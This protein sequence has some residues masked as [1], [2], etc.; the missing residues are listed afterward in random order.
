MKTSIS[1]PEKYIKYLS[2][3]IQNA[4]ITNFSAASQKNLSYPVPLVVLQWQEID[5]KC[6]ASIN[7]EEAT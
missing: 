1:L 3:E 7:A 2:D 5:V 4:G 6:S